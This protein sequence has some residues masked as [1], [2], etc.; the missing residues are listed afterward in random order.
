MEDLADELHF[1]GP[2]Q[3]R[4]KGGLV[5]LGRRLPR[6]T[7]YPSLLRAKDSIG[8]QEVLKPHESPLFQMA[9]GGPAGGPGGGQG[10]EVTAA[11]PPYPQAF[12][13]AAIERCQAIVYCLPDS[14]NLVRADI[15]SYLTY[16]RLKQYS[17]PALELESAE[18]LDIKSVT[19]SSLVLLGRI[20]GGLN[21]QLQGT[22]GSI[23]IFPL[24][25]QNFRGSHLNISQDIMS[26]LELYLS[27]KNK[28][29]I[30]ET[31]V[32]KALLVS[33]SGL[34]SLEY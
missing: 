28:R 34:Y 4:V 18:H 10:P 29:G 32:E 12:V 21:L 19:G 22:G 5:G 9:G 17:K 27:P 2:S 33:K 25:A 6:S 30:M 1:M 8:L 16:K 14:G 20:K 15:M 13:K 31:K 11:R 3:P 26:K 7:I 24:V 23:K